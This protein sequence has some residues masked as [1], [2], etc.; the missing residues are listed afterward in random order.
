MKVPNR[1]AVEFNSRG[2]RPQSAR[3]PRPTLKGS[4]YFIVPP[5]QGRSI[6]GFGSGGAATG[7]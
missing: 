7:Y 1:E 2:Q 5:F 4:D 6:R 3:E